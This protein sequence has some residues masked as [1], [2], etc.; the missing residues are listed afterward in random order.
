M[1][2]LFRVRC[3]IKAAVRRYTDCLASGYIGEGP[4]V[5]EFERRLAEMWGVEPECVVAVNS[6]TSAIQLALALCGVEGHEV[7]MPPVTCT[8][9]AH[10]VLMERGKIV[11]CDVDPMTG[12]AEPRDIATRLTPKTRAILLTDWGGSAPKD[13]GFLRGH[14]TAGRSGPVIPVIQDA[15]HNLNGA[16]WGDLAAFSFQS[17]KHLSTGD[18]GCLVVRDRKKAKEARLRRWFSLDRESSADFRCQ[19]DSV[20]PGYKMH[21]TDLDA[22]LG[23][24]NMEV[25]LDSVERSRENAEWYQNN[26]PAAVL[27]PYDSRSPYWIYTIL[28]ERRDEFKGYMAENG[29]AVSPVHSRCDEKTVFGGRRPDLPGVDSFCSSNVAI[30]NGWWVTEDDRE[31]VSGLVRAWEEMK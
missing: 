16:L 13:A 11:F 30:P 8:A 18:G 20:Y 25:A 4:L 17:I 26:L 2:P 21:M 12:N 27:C 15:A 29:V 9:D 5:K 24:A 1:I 6:G 3:D 7:I 28:V 14:W 10:A 23:L 22:A 31:K 19:Q